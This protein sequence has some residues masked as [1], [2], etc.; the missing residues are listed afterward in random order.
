MYEVD[1][2]GGEIVTGVDIPVPAA[3]SGTAYLKHVTGPITDRPCLGV[4]A[5]VTL[6]ERNQCRALRLAISSVMGFSSR[7]LVVDGAALGLVGRPLNDDAINTVAE[8][9]FAQADPPDDL[10]GSAWY[11]K[12]MTRVFARRALALARTRLQQR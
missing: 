7:P 4:A 1:L 12:Q 5:T 3:Q 11:R 9:A 2:Q 8:A 6:D 10:R